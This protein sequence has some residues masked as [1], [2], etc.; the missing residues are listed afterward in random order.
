ML[1][2]TLVLS[3]T[4]T[5]SANANT[6]LH[7]FPDRTLFGGVNFTD[8]F[9]TCILLYLLIYT[10]V[11]IF[12]KLFTVRCCSRPFTAPLNYLT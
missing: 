2:V 5:L 8:L 4:F 1:I 9:L 7:F 10:D 11:R 12:F 3:A 6:Q